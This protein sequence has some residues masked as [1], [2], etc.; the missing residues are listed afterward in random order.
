MV[1]ERRRV[2]A[3]AGHLLRQLAECL[4][5]RGGAE[6]GVDEDERPPRV[7]EH[8]PQAPV[9]VVEP[10]LALR[11]R[12]RAERAVEV[13]GPGVV[14]ALQRLA[15]A[16]AL[17]DLVA[18]VAADVDEPAAG[19]PPA[20]RTTTIG[21]APA[22][23]VKYEPGSS[24][25]VSEPAYC[26][27]RPKIRSCSRRSTSGS[28]YHEAGSVSPR[29][30]CSRSAGV[31]VDRHGST[32]RRRADGG[33]HCRAWIPARSACSTPVPAGSPSCTSASSRCR[34]RTSST[35]ATAPG[36]R[37]GRDR[38]RRSAASRARSRASSR[39]RA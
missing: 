36:S 25:C 28:E 34:T 6:V 9:G 21:V 35:S 24:S 18:A 17:G 27:V 37:T 7:D 10:G 39:A 13:V 3:A 12:R 30:S 8:R 14:R 20:L 1:L 16:A 2:E 32:L 11:A 4:R 23:H 26:H 5:E 19:R 31:V 29:S 22:R 38:W 33:L 15:A